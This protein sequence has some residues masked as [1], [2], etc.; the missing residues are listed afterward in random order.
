[1]PQQDC[2]ALYMA[3]STRSGRGRSHVGIGGYVGAVLA[4]QLQAAID[5]II[6]RGVGP[7]LIGGGA[8][9]GVALHDAAAFHRPGED[10]VIDVA[11]PDGLAQVLVI[12]E[13]GLEHVPNGPQLAEG[14][15]EV[16]PDGRSK[17][18]MLENDRVSRQQGSGHAVDGGEQGIVPGG[19]DQDHA[20]GH[21]LDAPLEAGFGGQNLRNQNGAGGS[22][23]PLGA[24]EEAVQ[25]VL[26]LAGWACPS[27][28]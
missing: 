23:Q 14:L 3:P 15:L 21:M 7:G 12:G 16:L 22:G 9:C 4:A 8:G 13:Q 20:Q 28:G 27:A 6:E 1:M 10:H 11:L 19:D 26:G 24:F 5:E 25:L 18:A 2:P 17:A